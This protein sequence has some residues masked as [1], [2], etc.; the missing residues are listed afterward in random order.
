MIDGLAAIKYFLKSVDF[1]QKWISGRVC[2][3]M[4]TW[5]PPPVQQPRHH[6][7]VWWASSS[8]AWPSWP[9]APWSISPSVA[10]STKGDGGPAPCSVNVCHPLRRRPWSNVATRVDTSRLAHF[11]FI[12]SNVSVFEVLFFCLGFG[13]M[14]LWSILFWPFSLFADVL[15]TFFFLNIWCFYYF[16]GC[17]NCCF[18]Y[19][20]HVPLTASSR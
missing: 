12:Y 9:S 1:F 5:S 20:S 8:F 13:L 15:L 16:S 7:P 4:W 11:S 17:F 6:P 18:W 19:A 14:G 10:I 2:C 3:R